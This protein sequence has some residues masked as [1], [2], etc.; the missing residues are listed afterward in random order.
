MRNIAFS[1]LL[2]TLAGLISL[3]WCID[4]LYSHYIQGDL[5]TDTSHYE[6]IGQQ[7]ATSIDNLEAYEPYINDWNNNS[8]SKISL[9]LREDLSIPGP[10]LQKLN[11]GEPLVLQSPDNLALYY[12]L[13][14]H[15]VVMLF[16]PTDIQPE[17]TQHSGSGILTFAFYSGVLVFL[18]MWLYPLISR[19]AMM[20]QLTQQLGRGD[21][22]VRM[23]PS[24]FSYT[25]TIENEFNRMALSIE[26][27]AA[28]NKLLSS[29][30]SHD[31]RTPLSRIRFG[32]DT[33]SE[34]DDQ[35]EKDEHIEHLNQDIDEMESLVEVLL[36]YSKMT[37]NNYVAQKTSINLN[38]LVS[39]CINQS[40]D[41]DSRLT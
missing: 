5:S 7:L 15:D 23:P 9:V 22:T 31:L 35:T 16:S 32:V 17:V 4:W 39:K 24:M 10:L 21:L 13:P 29:A 28:D 38:D 8:F 18:L 27:L 1:L 33:L 30:V 41:A 37:H 19:L 34:T 3:G 36:S 2:T 11:N 25:Q 12:Y 14:K 26:N 20:S 6:N 40:H